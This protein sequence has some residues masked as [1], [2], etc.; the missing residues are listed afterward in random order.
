[1]KEEEET[2]VRQ[3]PERQLQADKKEREGT[4]LVGRKE[5]R[6]EREKESKG[7]KDE[8]TVELVVETAQIPVPVVPSLH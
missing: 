3:A 1:M 2:V 8:P 4:E 6:R 7:G 5:G